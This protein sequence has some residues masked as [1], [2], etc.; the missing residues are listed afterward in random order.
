MDHFELIP[1]DINNIILSYLSADDLRIML[2]TFSLPYLN[3]N[4]I[5]AYHFNEHKHNM[6]MFKYL[7]RLRVESLINKLNLNYYSIN[8]HTID[9]LLE[10][11]DLYLGYMGITQLPSEIV[12][13]VNLK[14]LSLEGNRLTRIP[15][16]IFNLTNLQDLDLTNNQLRQV[17]P[18]IGRLVNLQGLWL[19]DN[20]FVRIPEEALKT[21]T[22]LKGLGLVYNQITQISPGAFNKLNNLNRLYL[23]HN[24]IK[25]LPEGIFDNMTKLKQLSLDDI[26]FYQ[27]PYN[28]R[29]IP[30]I[31]IERF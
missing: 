31:V 23:Q 16:E 5:N 4:T 12:E 25:I 11:T 8:D 24:N 3:W 20:Q 15:P 21:L 27:V 19:S 22:N 18:E 9:E 26:L 28:I 30:G 14:E 10:S 2:D 7:T 1:S 17:S 6:S 13:L 29:S